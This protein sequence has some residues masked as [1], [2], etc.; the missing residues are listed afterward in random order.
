MCYVGMTRAPSRL[1]LTGAARRRIFGEYQASERSRFIDE[2]AGRARRPHRALPSR[3]RGIKA[4]S[5]T[6][7]FRTKS[8]RKRGPLGRARDKEPAT[9]TRTK[10]Q[11][12]GPSLGRHARGI[13]NSESERR[14]RRSARR[15]HKLVR[16]VSVG[17]VLKTLRAK[18]ARLEDGV[19]HLPPRRH[20]AGN[21]PLFLAIVLLHEDDEPFLATLPFGKCT[22]ADTVTRLLAVPPCLSSGDT[23][24]I[25]NSVT[26]PCSA[27]SENDGWRRAEGRSCPQRDAEKK[28]SM[29]RLLG[30]GG[31][32]TRRRRPASPPGQSQ[33]A[34]PLIRASSFSTRARSN[35]TRSSPR[36]RS[37]SRL[38]ARPMDRT[39]SASRAEDHALLCDQQQLVAFLDVRDSDHLAVAIGG[40][41]VDNPDA[42]A[43]LHGLLHLRALP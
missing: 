19:K 8:V 37:A 34:A 10:N 18:Y 35:T 13:R 5:P 4:T 36:S 12:L 26:I 11:S 24:S 27:G 22:G 30:W 14:Q 29:S 39:S 32:R 2:V 6:T 38:V 7:E 21:F 20:D 43:G 41:D 28:R 25:L 3:P 17:G 1:V 15:R 42:A 33:R 16:A 9:R 31:A 23:L 40:R